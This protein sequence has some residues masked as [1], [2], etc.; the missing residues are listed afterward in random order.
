[1]HQ[2]FEKL[3]DVSAASRNDA[4]MKEGLSGLANDL[5]FES[6]AYLNVQSVRTT[7]V[8]NYHPEFQSLYFIRNYARIDP[9]VATARKLMRAFTWSGEDVGRRGSKPLRR[10]YSESQDFGIRSG[11]SIPIKTA[12]GHMAMLTLASR[13]PSL[14]LERDID[15]VAAASAVAQ[16]HAK[17]EQQEV[18]PTVLTEVDLRLSQLLCLRWAAEGKSMRDIATLEDISFSTVKFH[19]RNGKKELKANTLP[20]ATA[21]AAKLKLI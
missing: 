8:S 10:F 13:K 18:K 14:T 3:T 4:M 9:V 19:L 12:F 15:P 11:I 2:W 21:L 1:M 20:Q 16:L 6:Y 7:A 5:G 17:L